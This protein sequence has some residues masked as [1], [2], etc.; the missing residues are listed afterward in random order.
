[1]GRLV[2]TNVLHSLRKRKCLSRDSSPHGL[3]TLLCIVYS[4]IFT[5]VYNGSSSLLLFVIIHGS[6][7]AIDSSME[8]VVATNQ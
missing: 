1:M 2:L 3:F 6:L 4:M 7:N 8:Q 5:Y